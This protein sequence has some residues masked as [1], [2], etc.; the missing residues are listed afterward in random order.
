[1]KVPTTCPDDESLASG[2][3]IHIWLMTSNNK[4]RSTFDSCATCQQ[5]LESLITHGLREDLDFEHIGGHLRRAAENDTTLSHDAIQRLTTAIVDQTKTCRQ[6][7]GQLSLDFLEPSEDAESLG[8]LGQYEITEVIGRGGMGIVLES[9]RYATGAHRRGQSTRAGI[10]VQS[11]GPQAISAR[12]PSGRR[13]QSRSRRDH[14]CRRAWRSAVSGDGVHRR[15]IAPAEARSP[16]SLGAA[17]DP[18]DRDA[19]RLRPGRRPCTRS[20]SPRR[21]TLQHPA[22]ERYRTSADH[23]LWSGPRRRRYDHHPHR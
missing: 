21:Q 1:M 5:R 2:C 22:A 11:H 17:R 13:R 16:R 6:R 4:L 7:L 8:R 3:S 12:G 10:G 20:D 9:P 23:R 18:A 14:V 15:A 19:D